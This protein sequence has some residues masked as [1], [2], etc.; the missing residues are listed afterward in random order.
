MET[1]N[2][3]NVL[4]IDPAGLSMIIVK[5]ESDGLHEKSDN[6]KTGLLYRPLPL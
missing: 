1:P 3:K 6:Q 4:S 2:L 5:Y